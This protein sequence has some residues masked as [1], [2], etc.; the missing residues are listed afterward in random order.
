MKQ[1]GKSGLRKVMVFLH[2][3]QPHARP[4]FHVMIIYDCFQIKSNI[5]F[6]LEVNSVFAD[7]FQFN[8]KFW[9]KLEINN[10]EERG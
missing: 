9:L 10:S 3:A 7:Y 6:K 4:A 8:A 1:F 2:I 5:G